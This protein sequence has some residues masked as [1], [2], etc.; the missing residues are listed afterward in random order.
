MRSAQRLRDENKNCE[1]G[2]RFLAG[3]VTEPQA[4]QARPRAIREPQ[5]GDLNF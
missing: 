5:I 1:V 3:A 2:K 4:K